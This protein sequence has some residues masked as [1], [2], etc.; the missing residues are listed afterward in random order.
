MKLLA[1]TTQ[2][3]LPEAHV[4]AM[5]AREKGVSIRLLGTPP[6][7]HCEILKAAGVT[8]EPYVFKSRFSLSTILH[9]RAIARSWAPDVI[10][11]FNNRGLSN[12]LLACSF[13]K[14]PQVAY[15]GT[16]GNLSRLDPLSW[17]T[18]LHP[19]LSKI[20]CVSRAVEQY[21]YQIGIPRGKATTIYKGHDV[22]WYQSAASK[23]TALQAEP[24]EVLIACTANVRPVKGIDILLEAVKRIPQSIPVHLV[25]IGDIRDK[26]IEPLIEETRR[27][28]RVTVTGYR[29][30]AVSLVAACDIFVMPSRAR[31]GLPKATIEAMCQRIPPVVSGVGGLPELVIH[32]KSGLVVPPCDP[33]ALAQALATLSSD[34]LLRDELG[35]A[36]YERV[37]QHFSVRETVDQTYEVYQ[38]VRRHP[39][40]QSLPQEKQTSS[41]TQQIP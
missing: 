15:R 3:D 31:E 40:I 4:L 10:H 30:D 22:A 5:L 19:G 37:V 11:Y 6:A 25:L 26:A 9:L 32:G 7:Q 20:I 39:A 18:Y 17:T 1:V 24:H 36:A 2:T 21:L 33:S 12:G 35:Q 8:I 23:R 28:H 13:L 41:V 14:I 27:Y 38:E 16:T 34:P 29:A